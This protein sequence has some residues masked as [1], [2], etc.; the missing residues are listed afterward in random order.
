MDGGSTDSG[1]LPAALVATPS[2]WMQPVRLFVG[3]PP[4]YADGVGRDV[5]P[6]VGRHVLDPIVAICADGGI[7]AEVPTAVGVDLAP[8]ACV[9]EMSCSMGAM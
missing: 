1:L 7:D 3:T 8:V 4:D 2:R 9:H 6:L 5:M